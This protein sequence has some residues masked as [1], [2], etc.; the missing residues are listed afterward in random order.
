MNVTGTLTV[1][2]TLTGVTGIVTTLNSANEF[3]MSQLTIT[4]G[5]IQNYTVLNSIYTGSTRSNLSVNATN[6][7]TGTIDSGC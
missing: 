2:N 6:F 7:T 5:S 4:N 1:T 3:N